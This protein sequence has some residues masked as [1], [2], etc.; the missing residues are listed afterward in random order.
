MGFKEHAIPI[1]SVPA[2]AI[3]PAIFIQLSLGAA[4]PEADS[5]RKDHHSE[6][7][8]KAHSPPACTT[9]ILTTELKSDLRA[10]LGQDGRAGTCEIPRLH[11]ENSASLLSLSLLVQPVHTGQA[12]ESQT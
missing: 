3:L 2:S 5:R 8:A 10:K 12:M 1:T 4:A 6:A 11:E 9:P 7:K